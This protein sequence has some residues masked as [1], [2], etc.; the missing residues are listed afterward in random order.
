MI[1]VLP[2]ARLDWAFGGVS[3]SQTG[4]DSEGKHVILSEWKHW[5]D[6]RTCHAEQVK[7]E[8]MMY[9]QSDGRTL[10]KGSMVNPATGRMTEYEEMWKDIEPVA[11]VTGNVT[12]SEAERMRVCIVLML[13]DEQHEARGMVV[14]VGQFCQGIIRTGQYFSLERWVWMKNGEKKGDEIERSWRRTSRIGNFWLPCGPAMEAEMGR[15]KLGGEVK[16]GEFL[17]TVVELKIF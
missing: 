5:V 3:S 16:Y 14:R 7:D 17:W 15:L 1:D 10:E 6:S 8:G 2:V 11:T 12:P 9:S 4:T 13:D